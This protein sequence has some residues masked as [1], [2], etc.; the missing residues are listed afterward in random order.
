MEAFDVITIS[1]VY[2]QNA[3]DDISVV[4]VLGVNTFSLTDL[5]YISKPLIVE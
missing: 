3:K 5:Q 1:S 2:F 4:N